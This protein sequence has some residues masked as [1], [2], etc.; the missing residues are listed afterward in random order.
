ME[1][2]ASGVSNKHIPLVAVGEQ[3]SFVIHWLRALAMETQRGA[4]SRPPAS[5]GARSMNKTFVEFNPE[6]GPDHAENRGLK[7]GAVWG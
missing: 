5:D 4:N 1:N 3:S 7:D 6:K 2:P